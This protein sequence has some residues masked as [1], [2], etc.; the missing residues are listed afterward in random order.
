M[1]SSPQ[2]PLS[3]KLTPDQV[4]SR[5]LSVCHIPSRHTLVGPYAPGRCPPLRHFYP[6]NPS[7]NLA[8]PYGTQRKRLF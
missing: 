1:S 7:A 3:S 8:S 2:M 4:I 5:D 6:R